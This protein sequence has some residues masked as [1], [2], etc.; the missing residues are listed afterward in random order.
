MAGEPCQGRRLHYRLLLER[1]GCAR[2]SKHAKTYKPAL[3]EV[4][5]KVGWYKQLQPVF[6]YSL[7]QLL[8]VTLSAEVQLLTSEL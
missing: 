3:S 1:K 8:S 5:V 2:K 6:G 7:E 4:K